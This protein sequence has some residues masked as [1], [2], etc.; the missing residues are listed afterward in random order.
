MTPILLS[1]YSRYWNASWYNSCIL[2]LPVS[3]LH[4]QFT[5]IVYNNRPSLST[6]FLKFLFNCSLAVQNSTQSFNLNFGAAVKSKKT[7]HLLLYISELCVAQ[8]T[9]MR[10]FQKSRAKSS[11]SL[12]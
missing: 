9:D 10:I 6:A 12:I 11:K 3:N 1:A 7:I 4:R 8:A 5:Y 2:H